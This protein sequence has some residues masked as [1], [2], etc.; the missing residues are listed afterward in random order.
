MA[1]LAKGLFLAGLVNLLAFQV[2]LADSI[3]NERLRLP[4]SGNAN[5]EYDLT[6]GQLNQPP[7]ELLQVF[8]GSSSDCCQGRRPIAGK[9]TLAD[10]RLTFTP[11]FR[12]IEGQRYTVH[13]RLSGNGDS[14]VCG[15]NCLL[16]EFE[17]QS[18]VSQPEVRVAA[19]LPSGPTIPENTLRFY[20]YFTAPM[21][22]NRS[23]EFID[24]VD[25]SGQVDSEA[26]MSFK[27]ELWSEDRKRLTV[28]MDPG[29]IKRGVAQH[30]RLG[31]ALETGQSYSLVIKANW[32]AANGGQA[33]PRF[34]HSFQV[35][36]ALRSLPKVADWRVDAPRKLSSEPLTI[37]FD[38]PFDF[39]SVQSNV[40]VFSEDGNPISG[41]VTLT[42]QE[43]LWQFQPTMPWQ[44]TQV[45]VSVN[46]RLEDVAGNNL[47]E[48]LDQLVSDEITIPNDAQSDKDVLI[49]PLK[50]AIN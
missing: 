3:G 40:G 28:L 4:S 42:Q 19:I 25:A 45:L 48:L 16:H 15:D 47:N 29:R 24:L 10:Q 44:G 21:A 27:Q 33:I 38:R 11:A 18:S 32:P 36:S 20:V 17:L 31:P 43:Q 49:V 30:E 14:E 34:E 46:K 7:A 50:P 8:V 26:F 35:A 13:T 12:F 9:Y 41:E 1:R 22:A 23:A 39:E 2:G 5:V 6:A 37:R